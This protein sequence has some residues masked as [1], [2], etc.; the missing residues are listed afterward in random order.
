MV[1]HFLYHPQSTVDGQ[2]PGP[3]PPPILTQMKLTRSS[4]VIWR[5]K[6]HGNQLEPLPQEKE[7][8]GRHGGVC[9]LNEAWADGKRNC[10]LDSWAAAVAA[11][12]DEITCAGGG[13]TGP[14]STSPSVRRVFITRFHPSLSWRTEGQPGGWGETRR[15]GK[16]LLNEEK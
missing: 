13:S 1:F 3:P 12:S 11:P 7:D 6:T 2:Q 14:S 15:A 10:R 8:D 9:Q 5:E 4:R 16:Q